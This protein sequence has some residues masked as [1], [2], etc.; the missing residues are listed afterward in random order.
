MARVVLAVHGGAGGLRRERLAEDDDRAMREAV[1]VA[2]AEGGALLD[3]G[4]SALD[5]VEAAVVALERAPILNA[6]VGSV[7][8]RDGGVEMDAA[9]MD[10]ATGRAGA[11][12]CVT[13]VAHP[14]SLARAV[15]EDG[16][17]VLLAG[18]GA[19][20]FAEERG[21]AG[22]APEALVTDT[23]QRQ[24]ARAK[25]K[26]RV[27]L[28]HDEV[29]AS[30]EGRG[31]D[32]DAAREGGGDDDDAARE[33][34]GTVGAVARDAAGHLAAATSTGGMTNQLPGRVGDSPVIGAG[35]W[36]RD[37]SC[38]VSATGHG[39]AYLRT[40][41]AHE[42]DAAM[43]LAGCDLERACARALARVAAAGGSGGCIAVDAEGRLALPFDTP[44]MIRGWRAP[45]GRS[46]I[47]LFA[48]E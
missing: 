29:S 28:D 31:D 32:D 7:L 35:T 4:G 9:L 40:A 23:R 18:E 46:H 11:V 26:A 14:I 30:R 36:A 41:F 16:A 15:L 48:N 19:L 44:G 33:G 5:A 39:E 3:A 25:A 38:A 13:R 24:L 1:R 20:A 27:S 8:T 42:I 45:D 12:A 43:R 6:G 10:G 21:I 34:G 2:L 37:A 22:L 17:H 47:A